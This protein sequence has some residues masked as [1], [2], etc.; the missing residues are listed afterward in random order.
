MTIK[1]IGRLTL[2]KYSLISVALFFAIPIIIVLV[3]QIFSNDP[4]KVT[5]F[6]D[7]LKSD[8]KGNELFVLIQIVVILIGIWTFGALAG[9]LI[10]IQKRNK[11]FIGWLTIFFLWILLFLSCVLT[12]CVTDYSKYSENDFLSVLIGWLVYGL[13]LYVIL[14]AVHGLIIGYFLGNEIYKHGHKSNAL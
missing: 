11:F 3:Y 9:R 6:F 10:I 5:T 7:N 4:V 2:L 13:S 14:G 12:D 1:N 8:L